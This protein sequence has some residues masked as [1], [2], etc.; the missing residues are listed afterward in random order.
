MA[1][2]SDHVLLKQRAYTEIQTQITVTNPGYQTIPTRK[3]IIS[4]SQY[5]KMALALDKAFRKGT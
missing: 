3:L 2:D 1:L 4:Q 5:K